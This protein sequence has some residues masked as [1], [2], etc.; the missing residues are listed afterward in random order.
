MP[1]KDG[2]WTTPVQ[3]GHPY[4][5]KEGK[6]DGRTEPYGVLHAAV[7]T[8]SRGP[9]SP[10]DKIGLMNRTIIMRACTE[11]GTLLQ[12]DVP[13]CAIDAQIKRLVSSEAKG[14]DGQ[15]WA[16]STTIGAQ[17]Y[18]HVLVAKLVAPYAISQNDAGL[19]PSSKQFVV[20]ENANGAPTTAVLADT[21]KA[22]K[23]DK[24]DFQLHHTSPVLSNGWAFLGEL[25]KFVPVASARTKAVRVV[26]T[27]LEIVIMGAPQERIRL[28]FVDTS[29]KAKG[30]ALPIVSLEC[31]FSESGTLRA[32]MP[33]KLCIDV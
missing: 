32:S 9:V 20:I 5:N 29:G 22:A 23:C 10:A 3:P 24:L 4:T 28:S 30:G 27:G 16:T 19:T 12:P 1:A 15:V 25:G 18:A 14:P 17:V 2:F 6:S 33:D 31:V 26:G 7:A 21:I 13:A 11:D 8:L